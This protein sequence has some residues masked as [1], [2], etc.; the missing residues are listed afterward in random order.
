MTQY[1]N[2]GRVSVWHRDSD[3][4]KAPTFSGQVVAHRDIREGETI[5]IAM[6]SDKGHPRHGEHNPKAPMYSGRVSDPRQ[7]QGGYQAPS[8]GAAPADDDFMEDI[9][10]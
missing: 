1:D 4:P 9:P 2:R 5:D 3:N 8:S 6:W 10:F 7:Q